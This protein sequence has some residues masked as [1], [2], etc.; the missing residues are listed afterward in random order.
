MGVAISPLHV[1]RSVFI[2]STPERVWREFETFE[3]IRAWLGLGHTLHALEPRQGGSAEFSVDV[4]GVRHRFGGPILVFEPARELSIAINWDGEFAW[5]V[6][7]LWTIRLEGLYEGTLVELFHHGFERLGRD[8][9]DDLEGYETGWDVKHLKA[10]RAI[11]NR[12]A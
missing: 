11:V 10:L 1:R 5:P 12:A 3:R 6:P 4:D 7:M 8:A 9:G 2:E